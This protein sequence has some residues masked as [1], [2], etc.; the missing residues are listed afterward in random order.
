MHLLCHWRIL[1][2]F[3]NVVFPDNLTGGHCEVF[4]NFKWA[5][6]NLRRHAAI[7]SKII[8]GVLQAFDEREAA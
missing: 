8:I 4:A 3:K 6:V 2:Q 7:F 5:A 1:D